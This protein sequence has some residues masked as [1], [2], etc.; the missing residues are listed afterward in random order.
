MIPREAQARP[1]W[2]GVVGVM[3]LVLGLLLGYA[4][5]EHAPHRHTSVIVD[6]EGR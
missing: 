3:I 2:A 6:I 1:Q 5:A 4:I